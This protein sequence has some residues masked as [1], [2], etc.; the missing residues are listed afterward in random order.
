MVEA[1]R[2]S[3]KRP[4]TIP[5]DRPVVHGA[6]A[7]YG[8]PVL[9]AL[10]FAIS[11]NM[12]IQR[13]GALNGWLSEHSGAGSFGIEACAP[14]GGFGS[15]NYR[16]SG[17]L[18]AE[19]AETSIRT[20]LVTSR[21]AFASERP[22]V[23]EQVQ[24]FHAVDDRSVVYPVQFRLN[25]LTRVYLTLLPRLLAMVGATLWL[26]GWFLTR[27]LDANDAVVRDR[28]RFPGRFNLR[29]RGVTW[30]SVAAGAVVFNYILTTRIIG[31]LGTL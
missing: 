21:D 18:T 8:L 14:D 7:E 20:S 12:T 22:F 28:V 25:E 11:A 10:I 26:A 31:S 4:V 27:N 19:G 3:A 5:F 23:G 9:M 29:S 1:V 6:L 16:C 30:I 24:V 2:A 13:A 17:Q 15:A